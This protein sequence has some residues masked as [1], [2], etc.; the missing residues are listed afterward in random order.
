LGGLPLLIERGLPPLEG[1]LAL[2][3]SATVLGAL[4]LAP[5][6][7]PPAMALYGTE[8]VVSVHRGELTVWSTPLLAVGL[9][10]VY[11]AGELRHRLPSGS[12]V[13]PGAVRALTRRIAMTAALGLLGSAAV[14]AA[15]GLSLRGGPAAL[16]VGGLAVAV[17]VLLVRILASTVDDEF[18]RS[19]PSKRY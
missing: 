8:L 17:A 3:A 2:A 15:A 11:E 13:E 10:L 12:V 19:G 14:V 6:L 18:L 9:L 16:V 4:I 7:L 5:S 1:A